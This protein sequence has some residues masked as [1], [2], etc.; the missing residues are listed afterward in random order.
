MHFLKIVNVEGFFSSM[1]PSNH[2]E[3]TLIVRGE[4][5]SVVAARSVNEGRF[6]VMQDLKARTWLN[7]AE[8]PGDLEQFMSEKRAC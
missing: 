6:G 3:R 4:G 5:D 2:D 7:C 1:E 8:L